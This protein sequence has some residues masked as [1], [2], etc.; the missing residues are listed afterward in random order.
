VRWFR[1]GGPELPPLPAAPKISDLPDARL[2]SSGRYLGT[3]IDGATV[4]A[5]EL[6]GR[7]SVRLLLS[8]EAL[9][10]IRVGA[11]FR[12]PV[13]ALRGARHE[14]E[15]FVVRWAHGGKVLDTAFQLSADPGLPGS[16][17]E[18]QSAWV[19]RISKLARK[20]EDAA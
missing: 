17:T 12:I 14:G 20:Q 10:V 6:G 8:D 15:T 4:K 7:G 18:K 1:R 19:R 13:T 16:G 2:Q 11:A 9:D 5:R 3:T